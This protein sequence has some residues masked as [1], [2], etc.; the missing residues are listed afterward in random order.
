[1]HAIRER[2][3]VRVEFG[4]QP[5]SHCILDDEV[6]RACADAQDQAREFRG[7]LGSRSRPPAIVLSP[8]LGRIQRV[9]MMV[10]AV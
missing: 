2:Q 10:R 6:E 3:D 1:V 4:L 5:R 9:I 8:E 7:Y